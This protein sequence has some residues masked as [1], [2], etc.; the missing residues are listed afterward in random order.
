MPIGFV[1]DL[2]AATLDDLKQFFLRWYGPNNATLTIGGNVDK[3][4]AMALVVKYFG[5]IPPGPPVEKQQ[6]V[7]AVLDADRYISYVDPNIRF[8]ALLITYPSVPMDHPDRVALSALNEIIGIGRKSYFYKEFVL[9]Q[10][11]I[12]AQA[13]SYNLELS[14]L[15]TYFVLP[16]PG[17]PLNAFE[18]DIRKVFAQFNADSIS[19]EDILIYKAT[20]EANLIRSLASVSGK[21]TQ[22]ASNQTF[23]GNPNLIQKELAEIRALTKEDVIRVFETYMKDK[24]A[25]YLSIVPPSAPDIIAQPDNFTIP[26][27]IARIDGDA[28]PLEQRRGGTSLDRSVRPTPPAN[29]LVTMPEFWK[30]ARDNGIDFI[31]TENTEVPLVSLR[32]VFE[33]GHLLESP[34]EYG[35]A[36]LT[37]DMMN[38]GTENRSAEEFERNSTNSAA[39]SVLAPATRPSSST[40]RASNA[41]STRRW[42]CSKS[43]CSARP[44]PRKTSIASSS[45]RSKASSPKRIRARSPTTS[46]DA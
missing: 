26:S 24:P 13:F 37:A 19:D 45:R 18:A 28:A 46:I 36:Q 10:K 34:E 9:T 12:Q 22:L 38:E 8:P 2:D 20:Q 25:V 33:G 11:A 31:G 27:R 30:D 41:I 1:E 5:E 15:M 29:P 39:S 32:L 4:A 40:C 7:P 44:S 23:F 35:L 16:F 14:G 6:Q 43:V 21:V 42:R 3:E 17:T